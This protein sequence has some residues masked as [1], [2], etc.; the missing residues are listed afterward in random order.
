MIGAASGSKGCRLAEE[1]ADI[2]ASDLCAA[3]SGVTYE[4]A[5][6]DDL[7]ETVRSIESRGRRVV[8]RIGDLREVDDVKAVDRDGLQ[9]LGRIDVLIANAGVTLDTPWVEP[10]DMANGVLFLASDESRMVT[11]APLIID[12]GLSGH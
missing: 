3:V 10:E 11:G 7:A 4:A 6:A 2:I 5:T 9:Q 12:A 8:P 1:G